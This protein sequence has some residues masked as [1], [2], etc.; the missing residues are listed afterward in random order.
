M[1]GKEDHDDERGTSL[2]GL[3]V[4]ALPQEDSLTYLET[5]GIG[6]LGGAPQGG[7]LRMSLELFLPTLRDQMTFLQD[8]LPNLRPRPLDCPG[9]GYR[10]STQPRYGAVFCVH[11]GADF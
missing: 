10:R 8:K 11:V 1:E 9:M 4:F 5:C 2:L 3:R 6:G 7:A